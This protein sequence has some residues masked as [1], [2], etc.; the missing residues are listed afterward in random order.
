MLTLFLL[1]NLVT[2]YL[3]LALDLD[4][5]RNQRAIFYQLSAKCACFLGGNFYRLCDVA[6]DNVFLTTLYIVQ[7]LFLNGFVFKGLLLG[8]RFS[9][10]GVAFIHLGNFLFCE[11]F[12][13]CVINLFHNCYEEFS[14]GHLFHLVPTF[15]RLVATLF[16]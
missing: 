9:P 10:L 12:Q 2:L 16:H 6:C 11:Q 15:L 4:F 8:G 5:L 3:A 13:L 1:G 14:L 7:N